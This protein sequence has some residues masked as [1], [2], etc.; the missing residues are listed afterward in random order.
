MSQKT[1]CKFCEHIQE[2]NITHFFEILNPQNNLTC[3]VQPL[4]CV[5]PIHNMVLADN[6]YVLHDVQEQIYFKRQIR[7]SM[8]AYIDMYHPWLP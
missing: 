8:F 3:S 1:K 2:E 7:A 4:C 5:G 6:T